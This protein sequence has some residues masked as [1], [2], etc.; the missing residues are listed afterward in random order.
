MTWRSEVSLIDWGVAL[1]YCAV[2][3]AIGIH[4]SRRTRDT[5]DFLLGGRSLGSSAVG[6]SLFAT[7]VSTVTYLSWPGEMIR[8][9]PMMLAQIA[10]Y[11]LI[12]WIVGRFLIPHFMRLRVTSAYEL[13]EIRLG[14]PVRLA[15]VAMFLAIR[16]LWMA[17]MVF[18]ASA[19]VLV[20]LLRLPPE[21]APVLSLAVTAIT[22]TY[23][24]LGGIRT[25][26][27][28]DVIQTFL[29][30]G[31]ALLTLVLI[32]IVLGGVGAWWPDTWQASWDPPVLWFAADQRTVA[33]AFLSAALWWICTAGSDQL[34][35]QRY[36]A[37]ADAPSARRALKVSLVA[38]G[39]TTGL[40]FCVGMALL[41][42]FQANPQHIPVGTSLVTD[43]DRLF[44]LFIGHALPVGLGGLVI[45][46][47]LA[48]VMS[49]L[50]SG[51]SS[52][53]SVVMRDLFGRL[54]PGAPE[55]S[56]AGLR[57]ISAVVGALVVVL[58]IGVGL[59]EGNLLELCYKLVNLLVGPL[60]TVFFLALWVPWATKVGA[61]LGLAASITV[62]AGIAFGQWWNLGFLWLLPLSVAVGLG[63][64][65]LASLLPLGPP[66]RPLPSVGANEKNL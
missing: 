3:I 34:V 14:L 15:A 32:S 26:V 11:P 61:L 47:L 21:F 20:P 66:A 54:R 25:V 31:G 56:L 22:V 18:T 45:A 50:S 13:L 55:L 35:I 7:L 17:L 10:A 65:M 9:G 12:A 39:L 16:L 19:T 48:A 24:L 59:I 53:T 2:M 49:S 38:D 58:S 51:V 60:A 29:M 42:F 46:A 43:A 52:V 44:P 5:E 41:A 8:Y 40:V 57:G 30:I 33:G 23:T 63:G 4:F 64:G 62:A 28:T 1:G 36:L 6:L 27:L 37:T